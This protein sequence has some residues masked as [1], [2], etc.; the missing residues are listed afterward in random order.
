M[1]LTLIRQLKKNK[2]NILLTEYRLVI[3]PTKCEFGVIELY[4][5]VVGRQ[6]I[7]PLPET[8]AW[9][10][11]SRNRTSWI[12]RTRKLIYTTMRPCLQALYDLLQGTKSK[13]AHIQQ[14]VAANRALETV[15]HT[16]ANVTH[17]GHT[18]SDA[19]TV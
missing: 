19:S 6:G 18:K 2:K 13:T 11:T 12:F 9:S 14:M 1:L 8:S 17:L 16:I 7:Q 15:K 4:F 5:L 3:N 10:E